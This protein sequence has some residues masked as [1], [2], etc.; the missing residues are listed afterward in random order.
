MGRSLW[1]RLKAR[2]WVLM[3]TLLLLLLLAWVSSSEE[4]RVWSVR[5]TL[6]YRLLTA[7]WGWVGEPQRGAPGSLSGTVSDARG[8][9]I[10]GAEVLVARW[11]G[12]A[13]HAQSGTDGRFQI[14]GVPAGEY[15]PIAQATGYAP[16][17]LGH[18]WRRV[19]VRAEENTSLRVVLREEPPLAPA[20]GRDLVIGEPLPVRCTSPLES[21][22]VRRAISFDSGG[23]PSQPVFLYT[24]AAAPAAPA[25]T[26]LA[27]YP[28]PT[29]TW[30]CTSVPLAEA[31]YAVIAAGP[32]YSLNL[33]KDVEEL[34]R[35]LGF[36][37][38]G[39]LPQAD[40]ERVAAL[41]GSYSAILVQRLVQRD[42]ALDAVVLLG[43][44]TDLFDMRQGFESKRFVPP[45]GLDRVLV[46][47]GLPDR[48]PLRYWR[49]SA[50]YHVHSAMPPTAIFHSYQDEI[51]PFQQ[52]ERLAE[53]LDAA[54]VAYE[55]HLF[56]GATHYLLEGGEQA[57]EI[58][59]LTLDFLQR[60]LA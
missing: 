57:L 58:Y 46:A 18:G 52:S 24:P 55:L 53:A 59:S 49:Y 54:G 31:G 11:D 7:W 29:E 19:A 6:E 38:A 28:G 5:N 27:V 42:P 9:A 16:Q 36:V 60:F 50:A 12:T 20:P 51:V 2:R 4:P 10:A 43:P 1:A 23:T 44:P 17:V 33:E 41:G 34:E 13:Y 21:Q 35:L 32:A 39:M 14:N 15:R 30:E 40:G 8:E 48:A 45:F 47:L 56:D 26:L 3:G 22:A 25:A 37:R